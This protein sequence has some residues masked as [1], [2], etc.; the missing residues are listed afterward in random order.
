MQQHPNG[1]PLCTEC[2]LMEAAPAQ[3][4]CTEERKICAQPPLWPLN[5]L[6][7]LAQVWDLPC[8]LPSRSMDLRHN[9]EV[10]AHFFL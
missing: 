2:P 4:C 7:A 1:L 3:R 10:K 8:L 6:G 5:P 9:L